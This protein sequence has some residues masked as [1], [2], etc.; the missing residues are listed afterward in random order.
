MHATLK[1]HHF[2]DLLCDIAEF[3]GVYTSS[4]PYGNLVPV[5][6]SLLAQG[7]LDSVTFTADVDDICIPCNK[8]ENGICTIIFSDEV[9]K[10]YGV[11]RQYEYNL[12]LDNSFAK[13]LPEVF[14]FGVERSIEEIFETLKEKLTYE[15]I[16]LNWPKENRIDLTKRGLEM[17]I[18]ARETK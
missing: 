17:A 18:A 9:A 7:N 15:I 11:T 13:A 12:G 2:L 4:N 5:Y 1:P 14:G 8:L 6:G 10:S 3:G 16:L